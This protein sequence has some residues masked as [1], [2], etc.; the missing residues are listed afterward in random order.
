MIGVVT[1]DEVSVR[2]AQ[3]IDVDLTAVPV[4]IRASAP[5]ITLGVLFEMTPHQTR[6]LAHHLWKAAS[7]AEETMDVLRPKPVIGA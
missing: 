5:R 4:G 3:R 2:V 7:F 6:E 1:G